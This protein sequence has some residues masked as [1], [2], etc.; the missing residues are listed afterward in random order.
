MKWL[1]PCLCAFYVFYFGLI[2]AQN[3]VFSSG[4][5]AFGLAQASIALADPWSGFHNPAAIAACEHSSVA[6]ALNQPYLLPGLDQQ[7]FSLIYKVSNG[8]LGLNA[9]FAGYSAYREQVIA[10]T[11]ARNFGPKLAIGL[12]IDYLSLNL[13]PYGKRSTLTADVGLYYKPMTD[14]AVGVRLFNP[15]RVTLAPASD[16][17]LPEEFPVLLAFGA[18]YT[19]GE[20]LL[21]VV[22]T[23]KSLQQPL[24]L[25]AGLE[26][27]LIKEVHLR[28]GVSTEPFILHAGVGW[29]WKQMDIDLA[30]SFHPFLGLAP[31][32]GLAY[33]LPDKNP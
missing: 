25:R 19:L 3:P 6:L 29:H 13:G 16:Q 12:A 21:L 22:Q 31:T 1:K 7:S 18:T 24:Q 33:S 9:R 15:F 4:G 30:A 28:T 17:P 20:G 8:G 10:L 26:Y 23:D 32:M 14:L 2:H 5:R 27:A 11:Y